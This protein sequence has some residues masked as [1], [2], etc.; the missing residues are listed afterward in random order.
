MKCALTGCNATADKRCTRCK[1]VGYCS[2]EHQKKDWKEGG[3]KKV[4]FPPGA[5]CTRCLVSVL[6]YDWCTVN[7]KERRTTIITERYPLLYTSFF[8]HIYYVH[9]SHHYLFCRKSFHILLG[10]ASFLMHR[11]IVN[12][13]QQCFWVEI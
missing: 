11:I 9:I 10:S 8:V 6:C 5:T 4:C 1:Q 13:L 2:V 7:R 3:H 12:H